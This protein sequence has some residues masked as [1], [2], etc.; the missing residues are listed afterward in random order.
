MEEMQNEQDAERRKGE[1]L[2]KLVK[3]WEGKVKKQGEDDK[4]TFSSEHISHAENTI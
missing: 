2:L 4:G 3:W 1:E